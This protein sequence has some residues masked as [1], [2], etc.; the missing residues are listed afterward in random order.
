MRIILLLCIVLWSGPAYADGSEEVVLIS[1]GEIIAYLIGVGFLIRSKAAKIRKLWAIAVLIVG[2][3]LNT[4]FNLMPYR[5]N[6]FLVDAGILIST[7]FSVGLSIWLCKS[8]ESQGS[9]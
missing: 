8:K 7:M 9:E 6:K 2:I 3:G 1:I 4:Y 5:S